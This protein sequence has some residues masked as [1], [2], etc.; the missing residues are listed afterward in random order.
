MEL[1]SLSLTE[2]RR[3]QAKVENEIRRRSDSTRKDLLKKMQRM[4]ADQGLSL[5]EVVAAAAG[6]EKKPKAAA[7]K[8]RRAAKAAGSKGSRVAPKY[9]H[10]E[11]EKATWTGRGRKPLWVE[12]WLAEGGALE[13]LLI[14][15]G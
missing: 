14:K 8:P 10:P 5:E 9:R 1:S 4:A 3:L 13:A 15:Q 2:L 6:T 12:K 11:D 7:A